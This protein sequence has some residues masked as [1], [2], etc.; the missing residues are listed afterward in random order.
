MAIN[1]FKEENYSKPHKQLAEEYTLFHWDA[2]TQLYQDNKKDKVCIIRSN[3]FNNTID[4][5][6]RIDILLQ[7]GL[8]EHVSGRTKTA[9]TFGEFKSL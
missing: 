9:T 6:V 5:K 1:G 4:F 3:N 8:N 2:F 7:G